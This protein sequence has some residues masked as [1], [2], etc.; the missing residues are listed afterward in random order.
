[1]EGRQI[2]PRILMWAAAEIFWE[3]SGATRRAAATLEDT[4]ASGACVRTKRAFPVG[5]RMTIRW[6]RGEFSAI[7]RNCRTDGREFLLGLRRESTKSG[8]TIPPAMPPIP[9]LKLKPATPVK[10]ETATHLTDSKERPL[11]L[12]PEP[13]RLRS[14]TAS[15]AAPEN[16]R[17]LRESRERSKVQFPSTAPELG[18]A[19]RK[20]MQPKPLFSKF[21]R[22]SE[23]QAEIKG[24]TPKEV[25][26]NK[27]SAPSAEMNSRPRGELLSY[28]D[29]YHAAGIMSPSSGYG[30]HKVV[31]MLNNERIREL[32]NDIKRASVLMALE[33]AGTSLDEVLR[34]AKRRQEA[35]DTYEAAQKRQLDEFDSQKAKEN[36]QVEAEMEK[37]RAHYSERIQRNREEVAKE[38]E[39][40]RNWQAAMQLESQRI[41]EVIELCGKQPIA[42]SGPA[43]AEKTPL[44]RGQGAS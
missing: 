17:A 39:A 11:V 27:P 41:A 34:D 2:E 43:T 15:S 36:S 30:I 38:K 22:R 18:V 44:T 26:M 13:P 9:Q 40:L 29:I 8:P 35:L 33:S 10:A 16:S 12:Q 19:E 31:E 7:A 6:H 37:V 20:V 32:S 3:E 5:A 25:S 14:S 23:P 24:A 21:W 42:A 4:S 1:M 28:D